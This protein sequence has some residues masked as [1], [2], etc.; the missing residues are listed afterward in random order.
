M[1]T[2]IFMD[3]FDTLLRSLEEPSVLVID[4]ASY[5]NAITEEAK[6][7]TSNT[8]SDDMKKWLRDRS[9][10]FEEIGPNQNCTVSI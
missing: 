3:W 8:K 7:P 2:K 1:N 10:P 4:N 5:H 9:I 6:L